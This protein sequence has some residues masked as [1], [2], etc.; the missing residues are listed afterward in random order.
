VQYHWYKKYSLSSTE[1]YWFDDDGG[2]RV[3]S[4]AYIEYW[5]G[6]SW[7]EAGD[8]P[9]VKD[10]FNTLALDNIETR[11]LRV[12]MRHAHQSTGILEWRVYG[13]PVDD[14]PEPKWV[15]MFALE[16][17]GKGSNQTLRSMLE[18]IYSFLHSIG[19]ERTDPTT[20]TTTPEPEPDA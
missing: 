4:T 6:K 19:F 10:A 9:L 15:K 16:G 5:D 11:H 2:V 8:V 17:N 13:T 3:P 7:I 1:I 20:T 14:K 12:S 18:Y